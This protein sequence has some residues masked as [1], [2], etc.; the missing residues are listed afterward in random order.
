MRYYRA[1]FICVFYLCG[2]TLFGQLGFMTARLQTEYVV[3]D[4]SDWRIAY[5][6]KYVYNA[7][8]PSKEASDILYLDIGKKMSKC[9]SYSAFAV[10][11]LI[12]AETLAGNMD[13]YKGADEAL[14]FEVYKNHLERQMEVV[15]RTPIWNE[16]DFLYSD[17]Y[18]RFDW[19][20]HP[21]KKT[22]L[23]YSAQ[24]A[25]TAFRGR[26][27]EVWF[28]IDIPISDGPWKFCGLSGLIL[29]VSDAQKHYVFTCTGVEKKQTPIVMYDWGFEKTTRE[30]L[31]AH[32]VYFFSNLTGYMQNQGIYFT[33]I[34]PNTGQPSI[35]HSTSIPYNPIELE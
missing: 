32:L 18:C 35:T 8:N 17:Y 25:T 31:N 11:S 3:L 28:A 21:D 23:G 26:T 4:T 6:V 7:K 14:F 27:W 9:Y 30:K 34:D 15:H 24:K 2:I 29:E 10:D 20:L 1:I 13:P 33:V 22:I 5:S 16:S 19:E 12:T